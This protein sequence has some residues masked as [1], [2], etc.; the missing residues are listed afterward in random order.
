MIPF[1]EWQ[2]E[3][4]QKSLSK[5]NILHGG[6]RIGKTKGAA[7]SIVMDAVQGHSCLWVDTIYSNINRYLKRYFLPLAESQNISHKWSARDKVLRLGNKGGFI[8]FRSSD[9]PESIEGFGYKKIYLNEAGIILKD[10]YL[11]THSVLPMMIDYAD[12]QLFAFGTPKGKMKKDGAEHRFYTLA[13]MKEYNVLN[14]SS[15]D[16]PLIDEES[17]KQLEAQIG[18]FGSWAVDQEIY[19]L[20]IDGGIQ[21]AFAN[22]FD[23]LIHV[24]DYAVLRP[25]AQ[26][27]ISIDFNIDPFSCT[28]SS[29]YSDQTGDHIH[30]FDELEVYGG[31]IMK[32]A[33]EIKK[34]LKPQVLA[35]AYICGDY[36]GNKR[37]I[38]HVK[39]HSYFRQLSSALGL[40]KGSLKLR[41]NPYHSNSRSDVNAVLSAYP[42]FAI[43]PRS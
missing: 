4:F 12:S 42:D 22:S 27:W 18:A 28:F 30:I 32:M 26:V 1:F 20:F 41:P 11:Y 25:G 10:D 2:Y 35:N 6:R 23:R 14:L 43:H 21:N 39:N 19:G 8:D 15:Y 13:Q 31:N 16:N 29:V 37:D 36:Q 3:F 40:G 24:K 5:Y 9:N 34:K 7:H 38:A 33:K 17:L